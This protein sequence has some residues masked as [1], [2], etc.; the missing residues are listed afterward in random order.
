MIDILSLLGLYVE[1]LFYKY[2]YMWRLNELKLKWIF[3]FYIGRGW[4]FV[5]DKKGLN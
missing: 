2:I 4:R 1:I 5:R 3:I